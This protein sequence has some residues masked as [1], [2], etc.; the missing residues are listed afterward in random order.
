MGVFYLGANKYLT[1]HSSL[2]NIV[3]YERK[4]R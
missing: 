4:Y 1:P 3:V 2:Y